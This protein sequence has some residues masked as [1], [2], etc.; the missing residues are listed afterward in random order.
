[1]KNKVFCQDTPFIQIIL[2]DC[3]NTFLT[4]VFS[5]LK[6]INATSKAKICQMLIVSA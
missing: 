5:Q 6:I 4:N 3:V 1:M 2:V